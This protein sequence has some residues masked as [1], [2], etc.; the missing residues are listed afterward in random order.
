M[1]A[2]GSTGPAAV[3]Y[4]YSH[5]DERLRDVL[6]THL[7][8][9]RR[10]GVIREWH[11]R[12]IT[13]GDTWQQSID[14]NIDSAD[15]ILLLVSADFIASDYCWGQEVVRAIERHASGAA[16][17]I[18]IIVRPVD[19]G[20]AVFGKL[21]ALP[22][23]GKPITLWTNR[24]LAWVNVVKGIRTA[25]E[26]L[27]K[28]SVQSEAAPAPSDDV[29]G[30][31][32]ARTTRSSKGLKRLIYTAENSSNLPG[33]L[34]RKEGSAP[35]GDPAVDE[36]YDALGIT[37]EFF[38]TE[39]GRDSIDDRGMPLEAIVHY[40]VDYDN[41]F[42]NGRQMIFGDGDRKLFNRFTGLDMVAKQFGNGVVQA[43]AKL[44]YYGQ[45]GSL[46]NAIAMVFASLV[47]QYA[48]HQTAS[49]ADW[50]I[51]E[52]LLAPGIKGRALLS[53]AAPG[54]AYDDPVLGKDPQPGE[55][56]HYVKT[57][58]D[59]GG[60]HTN[61]GILHRAFY[62]TATAI[63]GFAW[64]KA[65]RIWYDAMR[66]E[67]LK[68]EDTKFVDFA[69]ITHTVAARLYGERGDEAGAV[70][71][72]W[73]TVGV[74]PSSSSRGRKAPAKSSRPRTHAREDTPV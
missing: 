20:G 60:V 30:P 39:F 59:N 12:R 35:L 10:E 36:V 25:V 23:N 2:P 61:S 64:E 43:T 52:G 21:Q 5:K 57:Q 55:M 7:S 67:R 50:L 70:R 9:L 74:W 49:Q 32:R 15:I 31:R 44:A 11:D 71:T 28:S 17:V 58:S 42:W 65:G 46:S 13:P 22:E 1:R 33:K 40:G 34:I 27:R 37:Y 6:A 48:L 56:R 4:S 14:E 72:A 26:V 53:L 3:F 68:P 24:D 41:A 45:S 66:D 69:R 51:G 16:R 19:W 73:E 18:P 54:T 8:L 63:G 29:A 62:L 47:K 38:H